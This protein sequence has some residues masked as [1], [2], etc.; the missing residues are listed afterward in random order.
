M[1]F[2][3]PIIMTMVM[4]AA[5]ARPPRPASDQRRIF[6][7]RGFMAGMRI[8]RSA[9]GV[10]HQDEVVYRLVVGAEA[11]L[12]EHADRP[13]VV[14][15]HAGVER[16]GAVDLVEVGAQGPGGDAAAPQR[17]VDPVADLAYAVT[18]KAQDRSG[19]RAVV[20][21]L[22]HAHHVHRVGTDACPVGHER[23]VVARRKVGHPDRLRVALVLEQDRQVVVAD[24]AEA[25]RV[26]H[27]APRSA[28]SLVIVAQLR[29][30]MPSP[31]ALLISRK[32]GL[33]RRPLAH[34]TQAAW[35][36]TTI[37]S[38]AHSRRAS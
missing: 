14:P 12:L 6:F 28:W 10:E 17:A 27:G 35:R 18:G 34:H 30:V 5:S 25:D 1:T 24:L 19:D 31:S 8:R 16:A 15:G 32:S 11:A 37:A 4:P 2:F 36:P 22:D 7:V 3:G 23:V 13:R 29:E 21:E 9:L 33:S 20:G 26:A 38:G